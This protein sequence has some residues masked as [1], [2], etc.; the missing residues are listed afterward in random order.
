[1]KKL[2]CFILLL[3]SLAIQPLLAQTQNGYVKTLGRP[4]KKGKA[5]DGVSIRVKGEHNPVLSDNDGTFSLLL[6]V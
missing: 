3:L 5:L 6:P 2:I 4:E 1:M